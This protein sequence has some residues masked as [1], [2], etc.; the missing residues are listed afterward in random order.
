[1]DSPLRLSNLEFMQAKDVK[2][3]ALEARRNLVLT[4]LDCW[5]EKCEEDATVEV[6]LVKYFDI[7][8]IILYPFKGSPNC[9][10]AP[11]L[12]RYEDKGGE[13]D[14]HVLSLLPISLKAEPTKVQCPSALAENLSCCLFTIGV[15][16][17]SPI[18]NPLEVNLAKCWAKSDYSCNTQ[19]G[20]NKVWKRIPNKGCLIT[21]MKE[22]AEVFVYFLRH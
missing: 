12:Q 5:V 3:W 16:C 4:L 17:Q 21:K 10:L 20:M 19:V 18:K 8:N 22:N 11:K 1:M 6:I 13:D 14:Q 7:L 15:Q 2:L 9:T